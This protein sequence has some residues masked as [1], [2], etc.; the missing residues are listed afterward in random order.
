[1]SNSSYSFLTYTRQIPKQG[2][3]EVIGPDSQHIAR[4]WI[5]K[6]AERLQRQP[7]HAA[8]YEVLRM[9]TDAENMLLP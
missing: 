7:H 8:V 2:K 9:P 5:T 6:Y 1:M 4:H 3:F